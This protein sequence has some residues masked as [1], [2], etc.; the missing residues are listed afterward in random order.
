MPLIQ[1]IMNN[2]YQPLIIGNGGINISGTAKI[3][4][5]SYFYDGSGFI[6]LDSL[7]Q[8]SFKTFG[9]GNFRRVIEYSI[10]DFVYD[11]YGKKWQI[12]DFN[13]FSSKETEYTVKFGNSV[14]KYKY[15]QLTPYIDL[16]L[17]LNCL[18]T[19]QYCL[20]NYEFGRGCLDN[21]D[22]QKKDLTIAKK[23]IIRLNQLQENLNKFKN[24]NKVNFK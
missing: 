2:L 9:Y 18:N 4:D 10:G 22:N 21:S 5:S 23:E 14:R 16:S 8:S 12:V 20:N 3:L 11:S 15:T 6:Y 19:L 1:W 7:T 13:S 17:K 24:K